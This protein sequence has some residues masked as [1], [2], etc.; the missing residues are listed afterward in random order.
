MHRFASAAAAPIFLNLSMMATLALAAFFPGA[1]YAAAWGVLIAGF[2]E[3]FLLAGDAARRGILNVRDGRW[4]VG[5]Q[6]A[7]A[8]LR[9]TQRGGQANHAWLSR[10]GGAKP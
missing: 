3:F 7:F 10:R 8:H 1:G 5:S 4:C 2:L 9:V 6:K